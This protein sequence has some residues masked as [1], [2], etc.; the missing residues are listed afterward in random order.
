M[1][2]NN[3]DIQITLRT[4][5]NDVVII[6]LNA[7]WVSFFLKFYLEMDNDIKYSYSSILLLISLIGGFLVS[8]KSLY[9]F[10][11]DIFNV[12][13]TINT[14]KYIFTHCYLN[15]KIIWCIFSIIE[16]A[17]FISPMLLVQFFIPYTQDNCHSYSKELCIYGKVITF[18]GMIYIIIFTLF[19]VSLIL[20][21]CVYGGRHTNQFIRNMQNNIVENIPI[22]KLAYDVIK[23]TNYEC[24]ICL[25]DGNESGNQ[26]FIKT[27]CGHKF[28]KKCLETWVTNN[29]YCPLCRAH[30]NI[31]INSINTTSIYSLPTVFPTASAPS[32]EN[33]V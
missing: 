3:K 32:I 28:H 22:I 33:I 12:G 6:G 8:F 31:N 24:S 4:L 7:L 9:K 17:S 21:Y 27:D 29:Q 13:I 16:S 14:K 11:F 10:Y 20:I 30:I 25:E 5:V 15:S 2:D 18:F 26:E 1:V 23:L 19:I